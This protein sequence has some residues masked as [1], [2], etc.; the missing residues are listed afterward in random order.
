M[1]F[2]L[3]HVCFPLTCVSTLC[4][5]ASRN[6]SIYYFI[7]Y[8][9]PSLEKPILLVLDNHETNVSLACC[10]IC[11]QNGI[12]LLSLP[13]HTSHRLQPLDIFWTPQDCISYMASN[14]DRRITQ[15]EIVE[16]F[17]K[18]FNR[19]NNIEKAANGFRAASIWPL[20]TTKLDEQFLEAT[21]S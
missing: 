11:R 13:P 4:N 18:A 19:I 8:A 14:V 21:S 3:S 16:L 5:L 1:Y 10:L 6:L 20:A 17:T 9:K 2:I 15:Y 7:S 12:V